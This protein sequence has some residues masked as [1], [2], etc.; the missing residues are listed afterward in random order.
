MVPYPRGAVPELQE[1]SLKLLVSQ[2][3]G[4]VSV[5]RYFQLE[6]VEIKVFCAMAHKKKIE[7]REASVSR[8]IREVEL[9][10]GESVM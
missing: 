2:L 4:R 9:R 10:L 1:A 7:Q 8:R 3:V 5:S 6:L